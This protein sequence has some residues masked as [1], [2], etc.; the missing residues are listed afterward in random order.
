MHAA[1][2]MHAQHSQRRVSCTVADE[3]DKGVLL[4]IAVSTWRSFL[5]TCDRERFFDVAA[6]DE[7]LAP[8]ACSEIYGDIQFIAREEKRREKRREALE[9][10]PVA[11]PEHFGD[12]MFLVEETPN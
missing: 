2:K 12:H 1:K 8:A 10:I 9:K 7:V 5:C 11:Q 3:C 6:A 4:V